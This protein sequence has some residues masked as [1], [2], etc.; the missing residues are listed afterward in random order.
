MIKITYFCDCC[1]QVIPDDADHFQMIPTGDTR[2]PFKEVVTGYEGMQNAHFC[3][4][5]TDKIISFMF[6]PVDIEAMRKGIDESNTIIDTLNAELEEAR[7]AL[8]EAR[9][10]HAEQFAEEIPEVIAPPAPA[11][12]KAKCRMTGKRSPVDKQQ[13]IRL[14]RDGH[15]TYQ[16]IADRVGCAVSTVYGIVSKYNR[17][18]PEPTEEPAEIEEATE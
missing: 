5:C 11:T 1:K 4:A 15:M 6:N 2:D 7:K 16:Q 18:A 9:K 8:E 10:A 14:Y 17:S 3:K 13:V 12:A